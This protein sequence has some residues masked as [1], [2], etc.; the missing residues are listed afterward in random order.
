MGTLKAEFPAELTGIGVV[1]EVGGR[2]ICFEVSAEDVDGR[3]INGLDGWAEGKILLVLP[4]VMC[5]HRDAHAEADRSE[6]KYFTRIEN[7]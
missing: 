2:T 6:P 3:M 1:A 5:C 7:T 4:F